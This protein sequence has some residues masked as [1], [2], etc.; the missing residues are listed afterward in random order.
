MIQYVLLYALY[1]IKKLNLNC[2]TNYGYG[3]SDR[4]DEPHPPLCCLKV[5]TNCYTRV[6]IIIHP[7]NFLD[8]GDQC[9]FT[10]MSYK[11]NNEN[12]TPHKNGSIMNG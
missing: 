10:E 7:Y 11:A 5:T 6:V 3:N 8:N 2:A 1:K 4:Y 12:T 9:L